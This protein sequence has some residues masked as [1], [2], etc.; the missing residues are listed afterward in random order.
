ME[1]WRPVLKDHLNTE[2]FVLAGTHAWY[3]SGVELGQ[4]VLFTSKWVYNKEKTGEE[5]IDGQRFRFIITEYPQEPSA[6]FWVVDQINNVRYTYIGV[7]KMCDT[8]RILLAKQKLNGQQLL[9]TIEKYCKL[10]ENCLILQN[11]VKQI[12]CG[13]ELLIEDTPLK[14]CRL[15]I[16]ENGFNISTGDKKRTKNQIINGINCKIMQINSFVEKC[17]QS[18]PS[19][20]NTLSNV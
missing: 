4:T 1:K 13:I 12:A 20:L 5:M 6:E 14:D 15:F 3:S 9:N 18:K 10:Q 11:V 17:K 8:I 19:C 16:K 7:A 2:D